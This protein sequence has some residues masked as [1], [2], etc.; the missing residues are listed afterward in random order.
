MKK[1]VFLFAAVLLLCGCTS[2]STVTQFPGKKG[3]ISSSGKPVAWHLKGSNRGLYLFYFIPIWSGKPNRPNKA[4]Y[5]TFQHHLT[6]RDMLELLDRR[7]ERLK[8][9]ALEDMTVRYSSSGWWSLWIL[10]H[11]SS[12]GSAVITGGRKIENKERIHY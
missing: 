8:G 5:D 10:W 4:V 9:D 11:R 12:V 6:D 3:E 7:R 2:T 1:I